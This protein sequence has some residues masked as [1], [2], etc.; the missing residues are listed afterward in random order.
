[1]RLTGIVGVCSDVA[2]R[3]FISGQLL[4]HRQI[5]QTVNAFGDVNGLRHVEVDGGRQQ[6]VHVVDVASRTWRG[7]LHVPSRQSASHNDVR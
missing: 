6:Q 5:N 7:R 2:Y 4:K 1:M 3:P